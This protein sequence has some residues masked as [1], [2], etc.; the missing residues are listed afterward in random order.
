MNLLS[1]TCLIYLNLLGYHLPPQPPMAA[2]SR[3][4]LLHVRESP[5]SSSCFSTY[6]HHVASI[7]LL[8]NL[9][10]NFPFEFIYHCH[11]FLNLNCIHLSFLLFKQD[12]F[13]HLNLYL[14]G[15]YCI[16]IIFVAFCSFSNYTKPS[17]RIK[18]QNCAQYPIYELTGVLHS[19]EIMPSV[20]FPVLF[21]FMSR[22]GLYC[23][24]FF[25]CEGCLFPTPPLAPLLCS[26]L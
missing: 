25:L 20:L 7:L 23:L 9:V 22:G 12:N 8:Q 10:K 4:S 21:L 2:S 14:Q 16:H 6:F 3:G 24:G 19:S 13:C 18:V 17:L 15:N 11:S 26:A 1:I 5:I